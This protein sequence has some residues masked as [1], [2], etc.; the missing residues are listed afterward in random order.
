MGKGVHGQGRAWARAR[1]GKGVHGQWRAAERLRYWVGVA[2]DEPMG[3]N[4]GSVKGVRF[5]ECGNNYGL[6]V[7]PDKLK[8]GDY[9]VIDF[10]DSE[11]EI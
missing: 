11:D 7:R 5:F 10:L 3:K 8:V 9:P 6:M 2:L 4:D 1:M